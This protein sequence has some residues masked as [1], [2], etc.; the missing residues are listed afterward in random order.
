M[1]SLVEHRDR[2]FSFVG[3]CFTLQTMDLGEH[4]WAV[5]SGRLDELGWKQVD[6]V[7]AS[8]I[9]K[10]TISQMRKK[11]SVPRKEHRQKLELALG[12]SLAADIKAPKTTEASTLVA[13]GPDTIHLSGR[14]E[15]KGADA[16]DLAV[17][18]A[19]VPG[20]LERDDFMAKVK[21]KRYDRVPVVSDTPGLFAIRLHIDIGDYKAGERLLL[22][23]FEPPESG[24]HV[25]VK[26]RGKRWF[27]EY[28]QDDDGRPTVKLWGGGTTSQ[29]VLLG[30]I[31]E[32]TRPTQKRAR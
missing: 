22:N 14:S 23:R 9:G 12:I 2:Q 13:S 6:L 16:I 25:L 21:E 32:A 11:K 31:I 1:F 8:G 10:T 7:N 24:D 27:G 3:Q 17:L 28:S 18:E 26:H 4:I 30:T 20:D 19:E 15:P 29:F 5:I